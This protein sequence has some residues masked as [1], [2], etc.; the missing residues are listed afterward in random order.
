[1]SL[2]QGQDGAFHPPGHPWNQRL[3][4]PN[5]ARALK[6][7]D[8]PPQAPQGAKSSPKQVTPPLP[9]LNQCHRGFQVRP[10]SCILLHGPSRGKKLNFVGVQGERG[11]RGRLI[12]PTPAGWGCNSVH[13]PG[14]AVPRAAQ[15]PTRHILKS[16]LPSSAMN[17]LGLSV[18][19]I[20]APCSH[21]RMG[22]P[23]VIHILKG[24]WDTTNF[25]VPRFGAHSLAP[26]WRTLERD[27]DVLENPGFIFIS[28]KSCSKPR[29]ISELFPPKA[30]GFGPVST[31]SSQKNRKGNPK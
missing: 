4:Q 6:R 1:M 15:P 30:P 25:G 2:W 27:S 13:F 22:C 5:N 28:F 19:S 29:A 23:H 3:R 7:P 31:F 26:V 8:H 24:H 16:L 14:T 12:L 20:P 10:F 11:E 18:G 9:L 21:E 17:L